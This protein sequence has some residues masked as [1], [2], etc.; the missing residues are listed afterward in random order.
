MFIDRETAKQRTEKEKVDDTV[1]S[2][3]LPKSYGPLKV[4]GAD[5]TTVRIEQKECQ[6]IFHEI[7]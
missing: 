5:E 3:L 7:E 2:K 4:L 6:T 1:R